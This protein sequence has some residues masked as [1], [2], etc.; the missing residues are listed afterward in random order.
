MKRSS[1]RN[2]I[3]AALAAGAALSACQPALAQEVGEA[4][5]LDRIEVTGSRIRQVE[6]ETAAPVLI[7]TREEIGKQGFNSV[8]DL[9]QNITA[10]GSPAISR[11]T[12]LASGEAVGGAYIDLRNLGPNRTLILVNGKR[13][14]ITTGG[15]QDVSQIPVAVVERIEVL[16]DG[17]STLYGSD[18]I[19]GV[20]NIITR[21]DKDGFEA[22]AYVGQYG[23]GDGQRQVYDFV[24]GFTGERGSATVGAE[25]TKED[26]VWARDRWFSRVRYPTGEKS[27]PIPGGL[28]G[29]T[30]YGRFILPNRGAYTLR[31]ETPGLDPRDFDNY[32]ALDGSDV[33]NPAE[34]STLLTGIERKSLF[35]NVVYDLSDKVRL[36]VDLLYTD[37]DSF[38]QNGGYP[39]GSAAFDTPMS[40]DSYYNPVGNQSGHAN[41]T[42]VQFVRRG[43]EVPR[44]V[45]NGLATYRIAGALSGQFDIAGR[46]WD[47]DVGTMFQQNKGVQVSIGNLSLPAVR[48]AVGPSF[49]NAQGVVQCG[50]ASDPIPLGFGR[51]QCTP[52]NPLLPFGYGQPGSGSASDP[53]VRNFIY[54]P[55]QSLSKTETHDYFANLTGSLVTLP[56]GDLAVAVGIEHRKESGSFSPDALAQ[57]G[58]STDLAA[59]PTGGGYSLDE[60]FVEVQVPLLA[61]AP[62]AKEL[63]LSAA[64]RYSDYDTFGD[65]TNSKLG[66]KW[67]PVDSLLVRATWAEGFRAPDV[68]ALYGGASQTFSYYTD[69]CDTS[70]GAAAN[71]ARCLED[72]PANFRQAANTGS[73]NANGPNS[74]T[75]V[76]FVSGSNPD[77]TPESSESKTLGIVYSPSF[78]KGLNL[79]LDWWTMRIENTIITD[80]ETQVLDDCYLRGIESRCNATSGS[81]FVRDAASG[82][83]TDFLTTPI[84]AGYVETEGFDFDLNYRVQ[85]DWGR[86][87]LNWLSTYVS[88]LELKTDNL[89]ENPP[90]ARNGFGGNFRFRSNLNLG[91]ERESFGISWGIRHYSSSKEACAFED[92]TVRCNLPNYQSPSTGGEV[93]PQNRSG[94]NAFHDLQL[95]YTAP[96]NATASLGI[97]N[98]FDHYAAPSYSQANS[99]FSYYGG[100]DIG[101]FVYFK[102]QQRF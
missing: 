72:V 82:A 88:K 38:A 62:G 61:D 47:W 22:N 15:F 1:L 18:A 6:V 9:L 81:R 31:R 102:Y 98:V 17:A 91:W 101:R 42:A 78:A 55:G 86:F 24:A 10:A 48:Q 25:Y 46:S 90:Q 16:K 13:L 60:V 50:S 65:T 37:R 11:S 94:S 20:V 77:L 45:R 87:S 30:Q 95:R 41:P 52:W 76:P 54:L 53:D 89:D 32:R 83:I 75:P 64:T 19:A 97:N 28:S 35:A 21:K 92:T 14:G 85:T 69:P 74:Q 68:S 4:T 27:P 80:T 33:S 100:Y 26:P 44:E 63:T 49:L 84:N 96:W 5:T 8:A 12:P 2:A 3:Q 7:I 79:S 67:R 66:L 71:N 99:G 23:Q 39:Y 36:D 29:T 59:G 34:Q 51:G 56:A 70:F 58:L 43:W 73:G 93:S 40:I 57:A